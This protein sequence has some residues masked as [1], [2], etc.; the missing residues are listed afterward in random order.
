MLSW[1][2]FLDILKKKGSSGRRKARGVYARKHL[3]VTRQ[4]NEHAKRLARHLCLANAKVVVEDLN[5]SGL[6]RNHKLAKSISDASWYNFHQWLEYFGAKFG[7]E[8]IA[9]PPHF[10]SQECSNCGVIVQ[11]SLSTRTHSEPALRT[12]RTKR[13]ECSQSNFESCKRYRRADGK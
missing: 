7:R 12:H 9:V 1:L 11:K 3:K 4:R 6:L 10:T 13:C 5:V 2:P 8:I